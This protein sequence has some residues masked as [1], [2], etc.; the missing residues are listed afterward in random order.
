MSA[1]LSS[2][3]WMGVVALAPLPF[4]SNDAG[5]VALWC[6]VLAVAL[7]LAAPAIGRKEAGLVIAV[8]SF[9]AIVCAVAFE[10]SHRG[11]ALSQAFPASIWRE[12]SALLKVDATPAAAV[13]INQPWESLGPFLSDALALTIALALCSQRRIASLLL[14]VVA[15]CG[16]GYAVYGILAFA[17]E[18]GMVLW[19]ENPQYASA[20]TSTF[21]NRNTAALYFGSCSVLWLLLAAQRLRR[22]NAGQSIN[23]ARLR[24]LLVTRPSRRLVLNLTMGFVTTAAM[25][26]TGSRA[27]SVIALAAMGLAFLCYFRREIADRRRWLAAAAGVAAIGFLLVQIIGEG[28]SA[29]FDLQ[30]VSGEGRLDIYRVTLSIIRDHPWFGTGLGTFAQALPAYRPSDISIWGTWDRAHNTLLETAS[31]L[32][33]PTT[34]LILIGWLA[35]FALLA[36]RGLTH[37]SGAIFPIAGLCVASAAALHSSIDFSLQTPGYSIPAMSLIGMGLA[38]SS[39]HARAGRRSA[40]STAGRLRVPISQESRPQDPMDE[41]DISAASRWPDEASGFARALR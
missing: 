39:T 30:G 17:A 10:Q 14:R 12:A 21:I 22:D 3:L 1:R 15:W 4:G 34:G 37:R 28:V 38:Q 32:G 24:Q 7:V 2:Y 31:D 20:L 35:A 25:F 6:G 27:G 26:M 40:S 9:A 16:V 23:G 29:R 19:R 18:P 41:S 13:A 33:L 36:R 8:V 5:V 11:T